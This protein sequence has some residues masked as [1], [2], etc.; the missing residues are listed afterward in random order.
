MSQLDAVALDSGELPTLP[1]VAVQVLNLAGSDDATARDLELVLQRDPG[2]AA[3]VLR[4]S[5]SAQFG[6]R[7]TVST[8]SH[9]VVL[10]GSR[11]LRAVVLTAC[12]ES[13]SRNPRSSFKDR[14]LW[15]HAVAVGLTARTLAE[16]CAPGLIEEAFVAGLL[17]DIGKMVL[18]T[19][20]GATYREVVQRVYNQ[21]ERF[22][23]VER[24]MF[25]FDHA[26]VGGLVADKWMLAESIGEAIALHHD[27]RRAVIN[28]PLSAIV[29]V[30][31][32]LCVKLEIGPEKLP[33][34]DL[35]SLDAVGC[36]GLGTDELAPLPDE[37]RERIAAERGTF[38]L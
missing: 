23:D 19:A 31:N 25:G 6:V 18:D 36:L 27:P 7:G 17:H 20:T 12:T 33:D 9:A 28:P 14:I 15:E 1:D 29:S 21:R 30:A 2:L 8:L 16:R 22:V 26:A 3:R 24:E 13:L 37:I 35:A 5:N 11:M 32:A 38:D 34:L 10:L 4:L